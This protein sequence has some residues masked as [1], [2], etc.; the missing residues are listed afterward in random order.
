MGGVDA[1]G[2]IPQERSHLIGQEPPAPDGDAGGAPLL[3][4]PQRGGHAD[5]DFDAQRRQLAG[6]LPPLGGAAENDDVHR[7]YPLGVTIRPF[8]ARVAALPTK[9]VV[10][11][12][13]SVSR[14]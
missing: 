7:R 11:I 10:N 2:G 3:F 6:K 14:S 4:L 1:E 13:T 5:G 9:T 8:S 12:S